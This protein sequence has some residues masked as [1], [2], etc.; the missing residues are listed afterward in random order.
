[1]YS[2]KEDIL[3][4]FSDTVLT[5]NKQTDDVLPQN[6]MQKS[7]IEIEDTC[8][9]SRNSQKYPNIESAILLQSVA[10]VRNFG[11]NGEQQ[12]QGLNERKRTEILLHCRI[13]C[14]SCYKLLPFININSRELTLPYPS[15][16]VVK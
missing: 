5:T 4:V 1:V 6:T 8:E 2:Y 16:C 9:L 15:F 3:V 7:C 12:Q 13:C 14:Y 10:K 11:M